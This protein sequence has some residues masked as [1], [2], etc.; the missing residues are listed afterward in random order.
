MGVQIPHPSIGDRTLCVVPGS[1]A[2]SGGNVLDL[3]RLAEIEVIA[4][5]MDDGTG[6]APGSA[7]WDES[8][9]AAQAVVSILEER[10]ADLVAAIEGSVS[11]EFVG[12]SSPV[13]DYIPGAFGTV[14][15]FSIRFV[16][17]TR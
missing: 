17:G 14:A 6:I 2:V 5:L 3:P 16:R 8:L 11:F 1:W 13:I 4:I 7:R 12:V 9:R 10:R 15:R